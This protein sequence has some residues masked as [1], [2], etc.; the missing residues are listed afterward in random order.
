MNMLCSIKEGHENTDFVQAANTANE[1]G[2]FDP[3][4]CRFCSKR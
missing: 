1:V 4:E 2:V 3:L